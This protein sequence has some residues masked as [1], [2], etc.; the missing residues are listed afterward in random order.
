LLN[1]HAS[2]RRDNSTWLWYLLALE[3]WFREY[4]DEFTA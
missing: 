1:E 2:G 4:P 3:L